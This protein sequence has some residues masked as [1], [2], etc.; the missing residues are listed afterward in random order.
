MENPSILLVEDDPNDEELI[1]R[2]LRTRALQD[3]V[4]V[5]HNGREALDYLFGSERPP[6]LILLD[7]KLPKMGGLE[8]LQ[9]LRVDNRTRLT[10][11]VVFTSSVE[12]TDVT[13][14]YDLG[15][16]S[17]VRK[18]VDYKEFSEALKLVVD[19]WLGLNMPSPKRQ[20]RH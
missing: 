4:F 12:Q 16:N 10:P 11:V 13:T 2:T 18:P 14:S 17:Y 6:R 9:A 7:L 20:D 5:A 19:Y 3:K 1:L 15:A 8:V